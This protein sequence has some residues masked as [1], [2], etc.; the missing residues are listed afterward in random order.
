MLR[1][2]AVSTDRMRE[3][4]RSDVAHIRD[5]R[6]LRLHAPKVTVRQSPP[7]ALGSGKGRENR[8][9]GPN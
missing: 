6:G 5:P 1:G 9:E 3:E 7:I 2:V 8:A 4:A